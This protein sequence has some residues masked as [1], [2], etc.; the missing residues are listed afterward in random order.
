MSLCNLNKG[1]L[2]PFQS[3]QS[4]L[5]DDDDDD[6]D[7]ICHSNFISS[8]SSNINNTASRELKT[9]QWEVAFNGMRIITST[10]KTDK[11]IQIHKD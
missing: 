6:D 9:Y 4:T 3:P 10:M 7:A 2:L 8:P 5:D 11:C 1:K